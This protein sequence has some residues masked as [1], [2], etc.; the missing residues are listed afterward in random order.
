MHAL[1][2]KHFNNVFLYCAG[3]SAARVSGGRPPAPSR[4]PPPP[5]RHRLS[6]HS[7]SWRRYSSALPAS[8]T[9]SS[10]I[11]MK[12]VKKTHR[13][14]LQNGIFYIKKTFGLSSLLLWRRRKS[15]AHEG[16]ES[17]K[18]AYKCDWYS[19]VQK[20]RILH[21]AGDR[22]LKKA[23]FLYKKKTLGSRSPLLWKEKSAAHEGAG[24]KKTRARER[25]W[26]SCA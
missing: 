16:A 9:N 23:L 24:S 26:C 19:W 10:R 15:A 3:G 5:S 21:N 14:W 7:P 11:G 6:G 20:N 13:S 4:W 25:A 18:R 12:S 8:S 17:K 1:I 2:H 22:L